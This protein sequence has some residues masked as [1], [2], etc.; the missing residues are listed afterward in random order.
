M[1][2]YKLTASAIMLSLNYITIYLKSYE[3]SIT[4][5]T[6]LLQRAGAIY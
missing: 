3:T 1:H 4:K 2:N 5:T 6:L